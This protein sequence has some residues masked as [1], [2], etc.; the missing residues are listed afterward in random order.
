MKTKDTPLVEVF[1]GSLWEAELVKGLLEDQ[2]IQATLKDDIMGTM[3][4]YMTQEV[5]VM[6]N[7]I[8]YEAAMEIIRNRE[9]VSDVE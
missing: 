5:A 3:A 9:E 1:T 2:G 4:P 7:E 8:D 6:I